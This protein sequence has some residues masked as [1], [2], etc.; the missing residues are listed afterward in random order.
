V[1]EDMV[2]DGVFLGKRVRYV[3]SG[4]FP[5]QREAIFGKFDNKRHRAASVADRYNPRFW[6]KT[7]KQIGTVKR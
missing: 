4:S 2:R 1:H 3:R 7:Q 6:G 5:F